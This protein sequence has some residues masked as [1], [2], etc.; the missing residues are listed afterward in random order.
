MPGQPLLCLQNNFLHFEASIQCTVLL[1]S[2]RWR[3]KLGIRNYHFLAFRSRS[4]LVLHEQ[5]ECACSFYSTHLPSEVSFFLVLILSITSSGL[6]KHISLL[7]S[8]PGKFNLNK[9]FGPLLFHLPYCVQ[10]CKHYLEVFRSVAKMAI[11][12]WGALGTLY[13]PWFTFHLWPLFLFGNFVQQCH[14]CCLF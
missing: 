9:N 3:R 6:G 4:W 14:N 10:F 12:K 7:S 13:W 8:D 1:L 2:S 11:Y 5:Q